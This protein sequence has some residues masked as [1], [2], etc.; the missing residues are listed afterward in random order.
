MVAGS[1]GGQQSDPAHFSGDIHG[2]CGFGMPL[3]HC[4]VKI[5]VGAKHDFCAV[6]GGAWCRG[7]SSSELVSQA[8]LLS[9]F[10]AVIS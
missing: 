5:P 1:D 8:R 2:D 9:G 7:Q 3:G 4:S 6:L 10:T